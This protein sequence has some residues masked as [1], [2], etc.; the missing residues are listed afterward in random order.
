MKSPIVVLT[1][2]WLA[3][4]GIL[5]LMFSRGALGVVPDAMW[6]FGEDASDSNVN[7]LMRRHLSVSSVWSQP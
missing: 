7:T 1:I 6:D 4:L 3:A 2:L 5:W